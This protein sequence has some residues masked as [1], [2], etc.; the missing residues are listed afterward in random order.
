MLHILKDDKELSL[1]LELSDVNLL[2]QNIK[3]QILKIYKS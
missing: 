3:Q 1:N 2:L